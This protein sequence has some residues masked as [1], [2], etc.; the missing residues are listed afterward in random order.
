LKYT[1]YPSDDEVNSFVKTKFAKEFVDET[2]QQL[3]SLYSAKDKKLLFKAVQ[4]A[5]KDGSDLIKYLF[6]N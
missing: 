3:K 5:G 2:E 4:A 6:D 1:P